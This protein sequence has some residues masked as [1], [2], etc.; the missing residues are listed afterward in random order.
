M[1]VVV[2]GGGIFGQVIAWRLAVRGHTVAVVEP[3]GPGNASSQSG[4]RSRIVR[5]FYDEPCFAE[6]GHLA[7]A[8]WARWS[9][10]LGA[11]LVEPIGV[12]YLDRGSEAAEARAW[13]A[14]IDKGVANV[15]ALGA[16]LD[17]MSGA[18][19]ARRWPA[20]SPD[21]L[22][23]AVFE[24]AG[25]FGRPALAART[26]A[27][28]GL[29]TGRVTH[30]PAAASRVVVEGSAAQGVHVV[31]PGD[32]GGPPARVTADAVVIAAG[33][34]G[35]AL[36]APFA[37]DLGIRHL[38]HWVAYWDVPYPEGA[39]LAMGRLP[40]WAD[41]GS[42]IYGFPD[43]GESGFK[44]A[45][46]EPRRT[47]PT[48]RTA[49]GAPSEA[50]LEALRSMGALFFPGLRRA[51]CRATVPCAYDATADEMFRIGAVPGVERLYFVGGMSGH[52]FKHAPSLGE[53]VAALVS[54]EEPPVNLA[55]YRF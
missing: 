52:G 9:A 38:P 26:I 7:L 20:L 34:H 28:A 51:T 49:E 31:D 14:W 24:P 37:G 13:S 50:Q 5:A 12:L 43:D 54:G 18:E 46:H 40:A 16:T 32:P 10:E 47:A 25:G 44:M 33:F 48:E 2:A 35:A 41:L 1:R 29:A 8:M 15:R 19:A 39:E 36:V 21:G 4:D 6:A 27:R 53:S 17:E 11:R 42:P 22:A 23:R 45:W 30:V 55:P 3:I